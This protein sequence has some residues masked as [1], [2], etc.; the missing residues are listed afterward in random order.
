M[1]DKHFDVSDLDQ[2]DLLIELYN[3]APLTRGSKY[4]FNMAPLTREEA[5]KILTDKSNNVDFCRERPMSVDFSN[6]TIDFTGYDK[7]AGEGKALEVIG[8]VRSKKKAK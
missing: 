7:H 6:S 8:K 5:V 3:N 1:G 2:I 4:H